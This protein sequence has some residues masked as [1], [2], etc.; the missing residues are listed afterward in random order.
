MTRVIFLELIELHIH[1]GKIHDLQ[2]YMYKILIYRG[3]DLDTSLKRNIIL[4]VLYMY[5]R[6]NKIISS[7]AHVK[8]KIKN[9]ILISALIV[10][11]IYF[12]H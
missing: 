6:Y 8:F 1:R 12:T 11:K 9:E 10:P 3:I 5:N 2:R 4:C 7:A